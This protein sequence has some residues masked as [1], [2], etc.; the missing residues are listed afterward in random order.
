MSAPVYTWE[1]DFLSPRWDLLDPDGKKIGYCE[2]ASAGAGAWNVCT[3][4]D[5]I[6]ATAP[7]ESAARG[8]LWRRAIDIEL[9]RA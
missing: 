4:D 8:E 9:G 1:Q 2:P 7:D 6:V 5:A 3:A